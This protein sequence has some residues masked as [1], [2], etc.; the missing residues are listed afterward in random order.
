MA[1]GSQ[2]GAG[3]A[4]PDLQGYF[5][6]A[7]SAPP[8]VAAL[9]AYAEVAARCFGNPSSRHR[10]GKQARDL[11]EGARE[12]FKE[13]LGAAATTRLVLTSGGT[14]ANNLVLQAA[15]A[16]GCG[17]GRVVVAED[18]HPS[19]W[20]VCQR[21][22]EQVAVLE[23]DGRGRVSLERLA[24]LLAAPCAL[25]SVVHGNNETGVVQDLEG[26]AAVCAERGVALHADG[27]QTVGHLPLALGGLTGRFYTFAGHKFGGP[28]G[29]GGV[30]TGSPELLRPSHLGG[31][32]EQG[33]RAGTEDPAALHAA[34]VAL[35][36]ELAEL[37][38]R[39]PLLRGFREEIAARVTERFPQARINSGK[40]GLPGIVSLSVPGLNASLAV[41]EMAMRGFDLSS[42]SAC[43]AGSSEPSRVIRALGRSR[44]EALGTLRVSMGHGTTAADVEAMTEALLGV[45]ERGLEVG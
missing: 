26:I 13:L 10:R 37:P 25:V 2:R 20:Q 30:L 42:G 33:L 14:E 5:D 45:V 41:A 40:G 32:Q 21:H 23:V 29:V 43:H 39:A 38:T 19:A 17:P 3:G 15:F 7:A 35:A 6:Y 31:E 24:A 44:L 27:V 16:G 22:R 1:A 34:A 18:V 9:R 11:L 8:R 4:A 36:A 12:R 28:R